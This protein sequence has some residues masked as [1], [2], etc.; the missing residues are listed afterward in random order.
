MFSSPAFTGELC[1]AQAAC[2]SVSV[3][4]SATNQGEEGI[5]ETVVLHQVPRHDLRGNRAVKSSATKR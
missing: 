1:Q 3:G 5:E 4:D 2:E